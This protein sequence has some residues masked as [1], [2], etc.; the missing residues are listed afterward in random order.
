[1]LVRLGTLWILE[2]M[3]VSVDASAEPLLLAIHV[4]GLAGIFEMKGRLRP[5]AGRPHIPLLQQMWVSGISYVL[6]VAGLF[7]VPFSLERG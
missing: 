3:K 4:I 1:M 5:L 6:W 2:D 7:K